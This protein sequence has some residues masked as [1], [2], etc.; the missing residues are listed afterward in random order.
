V[1][2]DAP[3]GDLRKRLPEGA[4]FAPFAELI[5]DRVLRLAAKA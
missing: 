3:V 2:I 5:R 4:N 1:Q